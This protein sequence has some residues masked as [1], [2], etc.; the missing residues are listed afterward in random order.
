M[1]NKQQLK[2]SEAL[3]ALGDLGLPSAQQNE[4]SAL[5]LLALLNMRGDD[6][7]LE[8]ENPLMGI[9]PIMNW[10]LKNYNKAYAP[11]TRETFRRQTMHQFVDAGI[12]L[13]NPD[14]PDRPVNSPNAVYQIAPPCLEVLRQLK[15]GKYKEK[16]SGWLASTGTL[17]AQYAMHRE[18]QMVP[19]TTAEG[20]KLLL[21]PGAHSE[22]I[23]AMVE[24]FGKRFVPGGR[25]VYAGD[26]GAKI[27][28]FDEK[29]LASLGVSVDTH[30][31]MP[32]VIL[33]Y[34]AKNWIILGE[35]ATSHG[36]VDG[37]RHEE[38]R[39]LFSKSKPGHVYLSA[40]PD[41]RTF[42][43]YAGLISWETEV[44]IADNPSHLI[45]FNG[46]RFL[47]PHL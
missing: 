11:N 17:T 5:C 23:R 14:K 8:A 3:S 37:K 2:I 6:E 20:I 16:L 18:M 28:F 40:F 32:D 29:L 1:P 33:Y 31:K 25:L 36:P 13:Y 46:S 39:K 10:V 21:S 9:T 26:T 45:H 43:K 42:T 15:T 38:L 22:L 44:W 19:V 24:E 30:G 34:P 47:G 4:R 35:A 41:R 27:G 7:W 12:A